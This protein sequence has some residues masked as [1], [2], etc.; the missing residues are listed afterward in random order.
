MTEAGTPKKPYLSIIGAIEEDA[1]HINDRV[2][3]VDAMLW[4]SA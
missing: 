1:K 2:A 3:D 4:A